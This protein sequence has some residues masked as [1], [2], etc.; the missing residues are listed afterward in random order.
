MDFPTALEKAI[1]TGGQQALT[2]AAAVTAG[3][4]ALAGLLFFLTH[5]VFGA[6]PLA[7][8]IGVSWFVV[9]TGSPGT[10]ALISLRGATPEHWLPSSSHG[11]LVVTA[12]HLVGGGLPRTELNRHARC[13]VTS[14]SYDEAAHAL[15]VDVTRVVQTRDGEREDLKRSTLKL[16]PSVTPDRAYAFARH[17]LE[18]SQR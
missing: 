4:L 15:T 14:T 12:E 1:A 9:L 10:K 16:D 6:L 2:V 13:R 8:F 11:V 5:T 7:I 17:V 18:L 3:G